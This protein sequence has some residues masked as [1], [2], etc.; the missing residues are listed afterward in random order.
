MA[1]V[2]R[3]VVHAGALAA[4]VGWLYVGE[5]QLTGGARFATAMVASS[6]LAIDIAWEPRP[7]P[8]RIVL[9]AMCV[10][11]V[12]WIAMAG[13]FGRPVIQTVLEAAIIAIVLERR[14]R[15]WMPPAFL[16]VAFAMAFEVSHLFDPAAPARAFWLIQLGLV[17]AATF[18]RVVRR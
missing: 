16:A 15:V 10:A 14:A 2:L 5:R 18:V 9:A 8:R 6:A 12:V 11:Y 3:T 7:W 13:P 4:V 17:I 1:P